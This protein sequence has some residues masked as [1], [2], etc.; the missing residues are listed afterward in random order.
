M[1]II[2]H[3]VKLASTHR[4][5][6][7][8]LLSVCEFG[9]FLCST[10]DEH[11]ALLCSGPKRWT[12][13]LISPLGWWTT[14]PLISVFLERPRRGWTSERTR[15]NVSHTYQNV[16]FHVHHTVRSEEW[17]ILHWLV[18]MSCV[19]GRF[20]LQQIVLGNKMNHKNK[21]VYL[22]CLKLRFS[23]RTAVIFRG[24]CFLGLFWHIGV[25][26]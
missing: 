5:T 9:G 21:L 26:V 1:Q 15:N 12:G 6:T 23:L 4:F 20:H 25:W 22:C 17:V 16:Y 11:D 18:R 14:S 2:G 8:F 3:W 24:F 7:K 13:S 10:Q 19:G